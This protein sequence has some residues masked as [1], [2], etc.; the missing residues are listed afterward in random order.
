MDFAFIF[1]V[2]ILPIGGCG[3]IFGMAAGLYLGRVK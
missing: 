1:F 2:F 3:F